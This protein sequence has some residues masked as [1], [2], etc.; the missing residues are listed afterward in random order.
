MPRWLPH[1]LGKK[2]VGSVSDPVFKGEV[3]YTRESLVF[4]CIL[5]HL[6]NYWPKRKLG[7]SFY[8]GLRTHDLVNLLSED[9]FVLCI[10][11]CI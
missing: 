9:V 2:C 11:Y 5:E 7:I 6:H 1:F 10:S 4:L 8:E 3:R